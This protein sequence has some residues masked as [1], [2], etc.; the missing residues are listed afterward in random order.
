[1]TEMKCCKW[2]VHARKLKANGFFYLRKWVNEHIYGVAVRTSTNPLVGSD[3]VAN[4][5]AERIRDK[6]LTHPIEVILGMK[7][8][9]GLD[10][11]YRVAWL[12]V[13][14][15]RGKLF[16]AHSI[17]FDPLQWYSGTVM[18]HNPGSYINIEYDD[19]THQFTRYFIS[20]KACIN[21]FI[22][23]R[24]LFFLDATFFKDRFKGFLLVATEK[25]GNQ[26]LFLL[27][28]TVVNSENTANWS[29]FLQ[30]LANV[31]NE[32]RPLTFVSDRNA[33]LLDAM[34]T[35]SLMPNMFFV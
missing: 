8:D 18:E 4:I 10:I 17:S 29:W 35:I 23:C 32:D 21:G 28:Y 30:H 31:L 13:E 12:G 24:P 6:P 11:T 34:P 1:M 3:F 20:F 26:A 16:G 27:A 5:M 7:Q 25:N 33:G 15:T 22:H 19:H 9:Y 2:M 14:K